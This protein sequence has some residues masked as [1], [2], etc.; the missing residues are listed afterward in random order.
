MSTTIRYGTGVLLSLL[1]L[2][3]LCP[4]AFADDGRA[5]TW[6]SSNDKYSKF[7][8][9]AS[10][11]VTQS[12]MP[13]GKKQTV[14]TEIT[15][16]IRTSFSYEGAEETIRNYKIGH[17]ITSPSQLSYAI[18]QVRVVPQTR[19]LQYVGETFYDAAGNVLWSKGMGTEKEMNSQQFDEEFY[20]AIIDIV[21]RQGEMARLRADDRWILLWT[22]ET[23]SGIKTQVTA[24]TSTM[25][26]TGDNLI[27][28]AWTEVRDANGKAV[29]IK[30]DKRA[31]NLPQGTERI[32][33]GRY[34][35]PSDG[36]QPLDDGYEGAYRMIVR[37][38][39]EGRGLIRLR[40][41]A[42]GYSTWVN[43]YQVR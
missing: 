27:F 11:R 1:F 18:A 6:L 20:A 16:D 34:W 31:V 2:L 17:V 42:D 19:L 23:A 25:R 21:F 33:T 15:A 32:V 14:A 36:W 12:V 24:D 5:W 10:V 37:E 35:S 28:W 13:A 43:R 4:A 7:Y 3:L 38:A 22:D 30:F 29:E 41:Y 8:A 26:R 9:P 39:P 40:A